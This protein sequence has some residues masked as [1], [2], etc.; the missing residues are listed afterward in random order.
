MDGVGGLQSGRAC[1]GEGEAPGKGNRCGAPGPRV[2][3]S[4][5]LWGNRSEPAAP[6]ALRRRCLSPAFA[7]RP[8][9]PRCSETWQWLLPTSWEPAP[10]PLPRRQSSATKTGLPNSHAGAAGCP[11]ER[12]L[13]QSWGKACSALE[14]VTQA[15]HYYPDPQP[16]SVKWELHSFIHSFDKLL[17]LLTIS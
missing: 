4:R 16:P 5:K 10:L 6:G 11:A 15:S 17:L 3:P 13:G 2:L 12:G 9:P 1:G 7:C 14:C 8:A